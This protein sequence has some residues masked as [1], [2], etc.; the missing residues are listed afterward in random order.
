MAAALDY[1]SMTT[2]VDL[3]R[4][5]KSDL[6]ALQSSYHLNP[7]ET[8]PVNVHDFLKLC[9]D[10]T[11]DMAKRARLDFR[12]TAWSHDLTPAEALA[13]HVYSLRPPTRVCIDPTCAKSSLA[14]PILRN[15]ELVEASTFGITVFT[16]EFGSVPGFSG[17]EY[18]RNCKTRYYPNYFAHEEATLRTYYPGDLYE[19]FSVMMVTSWTSAT[20]CARTYNA[21]L[22]NQSIRSSLPATWS[23]SLELHVEDVWNTFFL[24]S[25]LLDYQT[26]EQP[27]EL[28]H[29]APSQS[30]R[31][32]AA[33]HERNV[34]MAGTSQPAWNHACNLCCG[35]VIDEDG[36]EYAIRSKVTDGIT[37]GSRKRFEVRV[38]R[39]SNSKAWPNAKDSR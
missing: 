11:D 33:L 30:E 16:K 19:L 23:T 35:V 31:L 24:Y 20:N 25:L 15:R 29:K 13:A 2:Y 36:I 27:L 18:C 1:D 39:E 5:L 26:R 17:S 37:I 21:A 6:T 12:T 4:L 34:R 9:L 32:R 7:P 28:P 10:M 38:D 8:L 22:S 14:D 3:I